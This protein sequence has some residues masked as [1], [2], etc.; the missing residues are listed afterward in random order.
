[1]GRE[2]T[3]RARWKGGEGEVKALLETEALILR[4][5]H[6]AQWLLASLSAIHVEGDWLHLTTPDG[7]V[8]L[9]LGPAQADSWAKKLAKPAPSLAAKLG[10]GPACR[11]Q[12]IGEIEDPLLE[13]ALVAALAPTPAQARLSL[14]VVRGEDELEAALTAHAVLPADA[15]I[16]LVNVKGAASPF[17]ENAIRAI[18]RQRGF[19]DSK[20]ASVSA[21]LAATRYARPHHRP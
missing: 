14:A 16:W 5:G 1:M 11:V 21:A 15:P 4:G 6:R 3:C 7:E 17:G 8:A 20:T 2:A 18:M 12:V 13:K 10:V 19:I 9:D